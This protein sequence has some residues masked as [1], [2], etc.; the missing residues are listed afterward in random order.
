MDGCTTLALDGVVKMCA[1]RMTL[2]TRGPPACEAATEPSGGWQVPWEAQQK[3]HRGLCR[4]V[5]GD[6]VGCFF[7]LLMV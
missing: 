4:A 1:P 6:G 3:K 2:C 5:V 7:L